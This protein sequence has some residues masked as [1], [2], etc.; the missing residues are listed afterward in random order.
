MSRTKRRA[1]KSSNSNN[2]ANQEG[3]AEYVHRDKL[4]KL[5]GPISGNMRSRSP[6]Q[7]IVE[8]QGVSKKYNKDADG[9]ERLESD[10]LET[11]RDRADDRWQSIE[12]KSAKKKRKRVENESRRTKYPELTSNRQLTGVIRIR[13]LQDLVLYTLADGVAPS[14]VAFKH[15]RHT[16]KVVCLMVPGLEREMFDVKTTHEPFKEPKEQSGVMEEKLEVQAENLNVQ[17]AIVNVLSE[18]ARP[19]EEPND[20]AYPGNPRPIRPSKLAIGLGELSKIFDEWYPTKA[21][22]DSKYIRLY[23]PL[24]DMLISPLADKKNK[25][26]PLPNHYQAERTSIINFVHTIDELREA[27]YPVHPALFLRDMIVEADLES[28]RR[29][30]T[31]QNASNGWVDTLVQANEPQVSKSV[32]SGS[33]CAGLQ[34]YAIDCEMVLTDDDR[35]SLARISVVDW[36]RQPVYDTFVKP[37][38]TIKNY[39]TQF[40]GITPEILQD[41]NKTLADVQAK[42]QELLTPNSVILGHSLESDLNA[43]K[44]THPFIIDTALLY[45]HPR[46]MPLRSSLK[47]LTT[48]YLHRDIQGGANGH[49]SIEDALAVLDLVRLKC[50]KGPKFGTSEALGESLFRRINRGKDNRGKSRT[51]AIVEYGTPERGLGKEATYHIA[52]GNDDEIVEGIARAS[53]GDVD[54]QE[55]PAGGADF[56]WA[57]LKELHHFRGWSEEK[58]SNGGFSVRRKKVKNLHV[59]AAPIL[60]EKG[61]S[62]G[63]R[64]INQYDKPTATEPS[65]LPSNLASELTKTTAHIQDIWESLPPC[66]LFLI[67]SGTADPRELKRLQDMQKLFKQEYKVKKWD[68]LSVRWTDVDERDMRTALEKAREGIALMAIK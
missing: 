52:A 1:R 51:S 36:D 59:D 4:R 60:S 41:V 12:S 7:E 16:R 35:S 10:R 40:S 50:E 53:N 13:A 37:D 64:A 45:P 18:K 34:I 30:A 38:L 44:M 46:G 33:L 20:S 67:Y 47:Y 25:N 31:G 3:V 17:K 11:L 66:T 2:N 15:A 61:E 29:E 55:I 65:S 49:N 24:Q 28:R 9:L 23:S 32:E 19:S 6:S 39:F 58:E 54:G 14:W 26:Q 21:P 42:L 22:G 43:L 62:E 56:I 68:E 63:P 57:R 8:D 48:K 27:E 5:S